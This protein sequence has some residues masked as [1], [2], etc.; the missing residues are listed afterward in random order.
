MTYMAVKPDK[1]GADTA[2]LAEYIL[3]KSRAEY[4]SAR[5]AAYLSP[6]YPEA[7]AKQRIEPSPDSLGVIFLEMGE[8]FFNVGKLSPDSTEQ[9]EMLE[10]LQRLRERADVK[11]SEKIQEFITSLEAAIK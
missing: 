10:R 9:R 2:D 7:A 1:V 3:W 6:H 8:V 11:T 4:L 5:Y